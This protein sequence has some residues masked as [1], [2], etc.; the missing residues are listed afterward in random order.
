MNGVPGG[1][2]SA[3]GTR[4]Y[5]PPTYK[6]NAPTEFNRTGTQANFIMQEI[7]SITGKAA[8]VSNGHLVVKP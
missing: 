4:L 2:V 5:C 6:P 8:I 7:S 1:L 3:D